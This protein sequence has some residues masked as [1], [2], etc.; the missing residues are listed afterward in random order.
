MHPRRSHFLAFILLLTFAAVVHADKVDD[1]VK[2]QMEK[3]HLP[4]VSIVVIKDAKIVKMEGYGLANIELNV[5]ARPETVYKIGSVSKQFI[6]TG[7]MLL[8]EEGKIS[9]DDNVGKSLEGTPE[10]WKPITIRH[11]LTHTSGIVREAP[12]F[13]PLKI[14]TDADVIKTAYSLPLRFTPGEKYE[15][16]NVG[17]F[18]LA[19]IIS[20]VSGKPWGDFLNERVFT[21][22]G[23]TATRTTTVTD[24]VPNR[25]NGYVWRN[26]K[27]QNATIFLALRPS[28]A[29]LSTVIDL[30]KWDE[31]LNNGKLLKRST[32]EQMWTPLKLNDGK[33]HPYGFGWQL[34]PV[35][36]HKQV[37]HGGSLPGFRAQLARFIDDKVT[38]VVLTN[39]DNADAARIAQGV[40]N[41]YIPGLLPDRKMTR[42]DGKILD[43][44]AGQY[45]GTVTVSITRNNEKLIL[46][47]GEETLEL[48]PES[49][50]NFFVKDGGRTL[51]SFVKDATGQ[52]HL[53]GVLD[54]REIWRLKKVK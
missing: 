16:C 36:G 19:E 7:I 11:L 45:Q 52:L 5:P 6:A 38:V 53:A 9:L 10:S 37:N 26:G 51:F 15:Y 42:V 23:M 44:Y 31:A 1:F 32:L 20:K 49:E 3:Q 21:P 4:G 34:E 40:A 33:S 27:M 41:F 12:G 17:Y 30:A 28:G 8:I 29:F 35:N 50:T 25:A 43:G 22:L 14:Q 48:V 2:A 24:L 54:G 47:Q 13:D 18:T 39:G 46:K